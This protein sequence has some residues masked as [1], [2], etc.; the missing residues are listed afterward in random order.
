MPRSGKENIGRYNFREKYPVTDWRQENR[1][2]ELLNPLGK[3]K[4]PIRSLAG[5][6]T[7]S[8]LFHYQVEVGATN[9]E[10]LDFSKL[11][12]QPVTTTVRLFAAAPT[13]SLHG[14]VNSASRGARGNDSAAYAL[15]LVPALQTPT[16]STPS[17]T[18]QPHSAP[19]ML[20]AIFDGRSVT[21]ELQ[22]AYPPRE[23]PVQ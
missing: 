23:S 1:R 6:E 9:S 20:K 10:T 5:D 13:R 2:L 21:W 17:R 4:L 19:D 18:F 3:D 14:Q 22:T 11:L 12:G 7:L 15:Q 8:P 16:R